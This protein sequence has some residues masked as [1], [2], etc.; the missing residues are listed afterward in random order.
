MRTKKCCSKDS[1][2]GEEKGQEAMAKI[3]EVQWASAAAV[4]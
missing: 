1:G 4:G 2:V 3:K